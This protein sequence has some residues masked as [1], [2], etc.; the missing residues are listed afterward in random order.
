M[1]GASEDEPIRLSQM[2]TISYGHY[3]IGGDG[4]RRL[5]DETHLLEKTSSLLL[6]HLAENERKF[7]ELVMSGN[8]TA[9]QNFFD[10]NPGFKVNCVNFQGVSA[11]NIAVENRYETIVELLLKQKYID[12]GDNALRAVRINDSKIL[13]LLLDKLHEISPGLEFV[14]CTRSSEFPDHIT[15]LILACQCGHYEIIELLIERGHRI[16]KPHPPDCLCVDCKAKFTDDDSLHTESYRLDLYRAVCNPAYISHSTIDP[17]L[18]AFLLSQELTRCSRVSPEFRPSYE[19][20]AQEISSFAVELIGCCRTTEE[21]NMVLRQSSGV[22]ASIHFVYPR[23]AL[24]LDL[25]QKEF[26]AHPNTQQLLESA[27]HGEWHEWRFKNSTKRF[28]I[29]IIRIFMLPFM[30]IMCLFMPRHNMVKLWNVPVNKFI[31]HNASYFIFL[32]IIFMQSNGDKLGQKRAPPDSGLE[33]FIIAYVAGYVFNNVRLCA[34]LGPK[35]YFTNLWNV[36]DLIMCVNFIITFVFWYAS[37]ADAIKNGQVDL[38]RKYWHHLDPLLL[39]EGFFALGVIMAFYRLLYLCRI[40]Y[41]LGPLQISIGKMHADIAKYLTIFTITILSF[42]IGLCRF[43]AYYDGMVQVDD[44]S[45]MKTS[46]VSS[47]TSFPDALKTFFW[48]LFTMSPLEAA[49]VIIENLPGETQS[50]TIIN[51]H[52]FTEAVGY[53]CYALFEI[54][55]VIILLNMLIATTSNTFSRVTENAD[56]ELTFGKTLFYMDYMIQ[57]TLP[58]PFNLIPTAHGLG[59]AQEWIKVFNKNYNDKKAHCSLYHC[60][61]LQYAEDENLKKNFPIVMAQLIQRYF[62]E[63]DSNTNTENDLDLIKQEICDLKELINI[64][65]GIN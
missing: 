40:N 63:K 16:E 10:E 36:F 34:I 1:F 59:V 32:V 15:P 31:T 41:Y 47:F 2:D 61:Y 25:K 46:Q 24:A 21:M 37:Y 51:K 13:I 14:G 12:I 58:S 17:I 23:L 8:V 55:T 53:I 4:V 49:D 3:S 56:V 5:H 28:I 57:T 22:E 62:R 29:A 33:P 50:V 45:G 38:E 64:K 54:L 7:F 11:L 52:T 30:W 18:S 35:R 43:Y 42:S 9:V 19:E 65:R 60:C 27:W 44:A 6:P 48:G 39:A 20:L 26:V